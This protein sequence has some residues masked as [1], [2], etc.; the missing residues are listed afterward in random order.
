MNIEINDWVRFYQNCVLVI[1]CVEYINTNPYG[2]PKQISTT[3][4]EVSEKYVLEV[5]KPN[6]KPVKFV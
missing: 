2:H 3:M 4:G 6:P 5:R 1:G